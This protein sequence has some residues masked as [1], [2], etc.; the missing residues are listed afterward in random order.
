LI[1]AALLAAAAL[2]A[3]SPR[4]RAAAMLGALIL[5]PIILGFHIADSDQVEPLRDHPALAAAG[6]VV[7]VLAVAGLA[8]LFARRP[9][10]LR[11]GRIDLEPA[12][13]AVPRGRR[14]RARLRGAAIARR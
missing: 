12:G 11:V 1:V 3:P 9:V 13:A 6:A 14:R 2:V 10:W 4:P 7:A 8:V 5:A